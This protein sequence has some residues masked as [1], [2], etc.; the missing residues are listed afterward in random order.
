MKRGGRST[1]H[2]PGRPLHLAL[3]LLLIVGLGGLPAGAEATG[4]AGF[5]VTLSTNTFLPL[6]EGPYDPVPPGL[7]GRAG[8]TWL[9]GRHLELELYHV[10]Q[11]TPDAYSQVFFGLSAGWW[12]LE[13]KHTGYFNVVVDAGFLYGLD[14]TWLIA[15]KLSPLVLGGPQYRT[16]ERALA[17]GLLFDPQRLRLLFQFQL[18]AITFYL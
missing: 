11:I 10:P 3:V 9:P 17:V 5:G 8:V 2:G 18:I 16:A 7:Y 14:G 1:I 4:V 15:L 6:G 12:L 13:R